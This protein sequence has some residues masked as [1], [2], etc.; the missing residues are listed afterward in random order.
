MVCIH[1]VSWLDSEGFGASHS[2]WH[3]HVDD[4]KR[5]WVTPAHDVGRADAFGLFTVQEVE[6][7]IATTVARTGT[8][9]ASR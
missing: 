7:A 1:D 4:R 2:Y 6:E 3:L 8:P 5:V 9:W